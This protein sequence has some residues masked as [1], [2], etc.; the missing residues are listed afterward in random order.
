MFMSTAELNSAEIRTKWNIV[1]GSTRFF[2][3]LGKHLVFDLIGIQV[4]I[5]AF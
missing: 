3:H 2:E 4:R 5:I 1:Y